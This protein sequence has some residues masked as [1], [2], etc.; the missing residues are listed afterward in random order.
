MKP[1][2]PAHLKRVI[3]FIH[4]NDDYY[5]GRE[6]RYLFTNNLNKFIQL[7]DEAVK[8]AEVVPTIVVPFYREISQMYDIQQ[9]VNNEGNI[10]KSRNQNT[11]Q[12]KEPS[13]VFIIVNAVKSAFDNLKSFL[14]RNIKKAQF[15]GAAV[16]AATIAKFA[17]VNTGFI[18]AI[19]ALKGKG[20]MNSFS[21]LGANAV[22]LFSKAKSFVVDNADG[23]FALVKASGHLLLSKA[24]QVKDLVVA[25]VKQLVNWVTGTVILDE[26]EYAQAA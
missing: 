20:L 7:L 25:K 17:G 22:E 8:S 15:I 26:H 12:V 23:I 5:G 19:A 21:D 16:I 4:S 24:I 11:N 13:F 18:M 9:I 1:I 3:D 10:M 2:K 6:L 14:N